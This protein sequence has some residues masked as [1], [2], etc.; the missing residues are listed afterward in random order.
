MTSSALHRPCAVPILPLSRPA[1]LCPTSPW[2]APP[3]C[4]QP[5]P[6]PLRHAVP[7][8]Q[9]FMVSWGLWKPSPAGTQITMGVW[10]VLAF[11]F[12]LQASHTCKPR[13]RRPAARAASV[14]AA[15][16]IQ[17]QPSSSKRPPP[18]AP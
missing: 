18:L 1:T 6:G 10:G 4:A 11:I 17:H 3:R 15:S 14:C 5:P 12:F 2:P 7:A 8:L 9:G 16:L 13:Q